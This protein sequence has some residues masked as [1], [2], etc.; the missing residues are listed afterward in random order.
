MGTSEEKI[1]RLE[2]EEKIS[3]LNQMIK[4]INKDKKYSS[5]NDDPIIGLIN[6]IAQNVEKISTGSLVLDSVLGGGF[7]KGRIVE[8]FGAESSGKTSIAISTA[9]NVQKYGTVAYIDVEHAFDPKYAE[10][11]GVNLDELF[12]SQ[13]S[14][15]EQAME[16]VSDLT[17]S[18]IVDLIVVDSVA[19][20]VPRRELEGEAGDQTVGE[21]AR[22]LS[23]ELRKLISEASKNGT[24]I[25]FI[26]QTRDKIGGFSPFGVP[27]TTP[28]GQAL[29]FYSSQRIKVSKGQPIKDGKNVIGTEIKMKN[30]KNKIAPP[31]KEGMT[32]IT[33]AKGINREAEMI[34][35]G[36]NYGVIDRP[37]NRRYEEAETGELIGSSKANAIERLKEDKE[38]FDRL[39]ER[40]TERMSGNMGDFNSEENFDEDVEL[41]EDYTEED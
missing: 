35:E 37:N 6:N 13:P 21:L 22:L 19:A 16:L 8:I 31:F 26:N 2:K 25:I 38:L 17:K 18:K 34:E 20:L 33:Y 4:G 30:I 14:S 36:A 23:K 32:V 28:G 9:A 41:E 1:N 24:T 11:L 3:M 12:F 15:A 7:G 40:L 29:K 27:Q 10:A 5:A 39:T